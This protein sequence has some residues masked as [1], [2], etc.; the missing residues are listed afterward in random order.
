M[1]YIYSIDR[2]KV[3]LSLSADD[4][5]VWFQAPAAAASAVQVT[6]RAQ[7]SSTAQDGTLPCCFDRVMLLHQSGAT[8]SAFAT[9]RDAL[10]TRHLNQ[11]QRTLPVYIEPT[12]GLRLVTTNE[13]IVRF[14]HETSELQQTQLLSSLKLQKVRQNEFHSAQFIVAPIGGVDET[15]TLELANTLSEQVE[16]VEF[17]TP[18]FIAEYRKAALPNDPLLYAQWHLH[19]KGEN[20]ALAGEDVAARAAWALVDGGKPSVVIAIVDDGVDIDHPDLK[21]NIWTNPN[22]TAPDQHGRNFYDNDYDPRPRYFQPPYDYLDGNDIHGTACAGVAA[23][24]SNRRGGVGIAFNCQILPVKIFGAE[25]LAPTDRVADAIRYAGRHAQII[26]CSW[27]SPTNPDLESALTDTAQKGRGGK[28]CLIFAAVG[29]TQTAA[30]GFPAAH[31]LVFGIGASNDQGRRA[32]Y[33]NYGEGIDFVAPSSDPSSGRSD[34]LTTDVARRRRGFTLYGAYARNF[35]GTSAATSLAAGIAALV[36]SANPTLTRK[37]VYTILQ[38]SAV[39]IDEA[40]GEYQNGYSLQY[41]YGRL[42]A[43]QAV[44]HALDY[45]Q[46]PLP[47]AD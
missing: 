8:A 6:R 29:N 15:V 43:H 30:I 24:A 12:S 44:Q 38:D 21:P 4:I 36:L 31:P 20:G 10:P 16:R 19:N 11:V 45:A 40:A 1:A 39:K 3:Q 41:G 26:S 7:V 27:T 2:Q 25:A 35:G 17:A 13:I 37:Q 22:P 33:S 47:T 34:I 42:D 9:V 14:R 5:G 32:Q 46:E 28:G 23:A 18:N